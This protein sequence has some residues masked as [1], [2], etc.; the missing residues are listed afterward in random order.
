MRN[1][2]YEGY[3]PQRRLDI[4][5][6]YTIHYFEYY[7]GYRF[8]GE[9]HDFWEFIYADR[10]AINVCAGDTEFTLR[11]GQLLFH[12]PGE[13][14][15][16]STAPGSAANAIVV[17][18]GCASEM[19]YRLA[20]H[21]LSVSQPERQLLSDIVTE[22][23]AAF[24]N[25]LGDTAYT[26]LIPSGDGAF[27]AEQYILTML[28]TLLIRLIR[29]ASGSGK[30][31]DDVRPASDECIIIA[32]EYISRNLD[33]VLSLD[34]ISA[35]VG[36]SSAHLERL[37]RR[38]IGMS[39]MQYCRMRRVERAKELLREGMMSVTA[40]AAATGFASVHYFSRAFK[41][42][43]GM[44]PREYVKSIKSM[45]DSPKA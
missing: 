32:D 31:T 17:S 10:G 26:R 9:A 45:A 22:A 27:A 42:V 28:E 3:T 43:V 23:R 40:V 4:T 18:F 29:R 37:C 20:G 5:E 34:T 1:G 41:A 39:V 44:S 33:A 19:L 16:V 36:V 13:F 14:H 7:Q 12:P 35:A 30:L 25:D 11:Q 38:S 8:K 21:V 6:L 2:I 24:M 15:T